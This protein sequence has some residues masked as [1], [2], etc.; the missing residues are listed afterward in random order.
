MNS[1]QKSEQ[2]GRTTLEVINDVHLLKWQKKT[3]V[4]DNYI[5]S[6]I[7]RILTNDMGYSAEKK[8]PMMMHSEFVPFMI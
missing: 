3:V 1:L 8:V 4:V 7:P 6:N 2:K 5:Y